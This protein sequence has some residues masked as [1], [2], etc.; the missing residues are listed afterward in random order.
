MQRLDNAMAVPLQAVTVR[1]VKKEADAEPEEVVFVLR[2]GQFA[3]IRPVVTGISDSKYIVIKEGL[4]VGEEIVTGPYRML[5]KEMTDSM[6]VKVMNDP[7]KPAA[8]T[9]EDKSAGQ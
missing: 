4:Q 5:S 9:A 1:K 7:I 8:K 3:Q 6:R 2:E